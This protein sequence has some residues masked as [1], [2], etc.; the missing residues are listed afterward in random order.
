[1]KKILVAGIVLVLVMVF[2]TAAWGLNTPA[3][4]KGHGVLTGS[5]VNDIGFIVGGEY[6][7]APKFEVIANVGEHSYTKLG[8]KYQLNSNL[9]L[10]GGI[11]GSGS[12]NAFLGI[13]G[14][15]SI[16]KKLQGILQADLSIVNNDLVTIGELGVKYNLDRKLDI[17]GGIYLTSGNGNTTTNL[18]LG[19]GYVF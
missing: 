13:D 14:A 9:A 18:Q 6:S 12:S 5:Y 2:S 4:T 17:R 3:M 15:T 16:T 10:E 1:V 7:F 11:M 19:V 8:V